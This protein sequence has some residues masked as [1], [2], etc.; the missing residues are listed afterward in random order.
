MRSITAAVL[1]A[2]LFQAQA[3]FGS[4]RA[5]FIDGVASVTATDHLGREFKATIRSIPTPIEFPYK[6]GFRWGA[7]TS[8]PERIIQSAE[9]RRSNSVIFVPLSAFADL[10]NPDSIRLEM[11]RKG[12]R[13]L[14]TGG[15]ASTAYEATLTFN[16]DFVV[17]RKV[18]SLSFPRTAWEETVYSYTTESR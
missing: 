9:V 18:A 12:F 16:D 14:I 11:D 4:E 10:G 13:I 15:D 7:E 2:I 3:A 5:R 8:K 1:M 6:H 17:R